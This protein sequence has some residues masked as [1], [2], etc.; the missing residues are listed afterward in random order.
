MKLDLSPN[1]AVSLADLL[2]KLFKCHSPKPLPSVAFKLALG[3]FAVQLRGDFAM[4]LPDDKT[5][6]ASVAFTDAKGKP[7]KVDGIPIWASDNEDAATVAANADGMSAVVTP[8]AL[9][10]DEPW[11]ANITVT[12]DADLGEGSKPIIGTGS[13]TVTGGAASVVEITFGQPA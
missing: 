1:E 4:L 8:G 11:T 2:C 7:A 13:V 9:A 6:S 3:N 12:A 5:V 10:G